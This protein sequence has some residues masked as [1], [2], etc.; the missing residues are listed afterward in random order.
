MTYN[1]LT[2]DEDRNRSRINKASVAA[3]PGREQIKH[4]LIGTP[5]SVT[6]T[7]QALHRLG[8]VQIGE[9]SPL[10]PSPNPGEVMSILVRHI[11]VQ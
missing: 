6:S 7:Q 3:N 4:M 8:Y 11:L 2:S 1:Y 9:W 5:T 10:M